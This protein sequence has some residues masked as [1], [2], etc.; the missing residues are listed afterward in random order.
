MSDTR[1]K[2]LDWLLE[3]RDPGVRFFALRDLLDVPSDDPQLLAARRDTVNKSPVK[4]ILDAQHGEGYWV[5]SGSGYLPKY[6]STLW[7]LIHLGQFGADG[8][9]T[10]VKQAADYVLD[11]A[12][13]PH[14]GFSMNANK[15][16]MNNNRSAASNIARSACATDNN[17]YSVLSSMNWMPVRA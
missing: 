8:Q 5:K 7:Q 3:K 4:A 17:W 11:N 16:G 1:D 13:S 12:R 6:K 9:D 15:S 10:R 2:V 14:G